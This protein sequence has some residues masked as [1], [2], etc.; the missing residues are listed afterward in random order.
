MQ[1]PRISFVV[2]MSKQTRAIGKNNDLLWRIPRDQRFFKEV[3]MGHPMIMGSKTFD[4]I[5]RVLPGRASIVLTRNKDWIQKGVVVCH[6]I[7]SCIEKATQLDP[8]EVCIIGGG[9]VFTLALPYV[10]RIYL[11]E[12]DDAVEGDAYF[13]TYDETLFTEVNK[14]EGTHEGLSFTIRTLDKKG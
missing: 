2:A 6:T 10:N 7:A 9:E 12:V 5:G 13:P 8:E 3:T 4:S 14:E 1:K 11:T